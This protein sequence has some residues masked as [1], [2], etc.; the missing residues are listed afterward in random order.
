[1]IE[2]RNISRHEQVQLMCA[3]NAISENQEDD[4][5]KSRIELVTWL[6]EITN[7]AML[8]L[9]WRTKVNGEPNYILN[10]LEK[11]HQLAQLNK[12]CQLWRIQV[13]NLGN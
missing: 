7:L 2:R 9:Q 3:A 12:I 10:K 11:H 1:M 6:V 8:Y 13:S 5:D 4:L